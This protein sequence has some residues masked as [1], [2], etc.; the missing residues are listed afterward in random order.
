MTS[1]GLPHQVKPRTDLAASLGTSSL[2]E[3]PMIEQL[4][5]RNIERNKALF[6]EL[7]LEEGL[8]PA[9]SPR[10]RLPRPARPALHARRLPSRGQRAAAAQPP[11]DEYT[12]GFDFGCVDISPTDIKD[13][14]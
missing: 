6:K 12:L 14:I 13:I 8:V 9:A 11:L 2:E 3:L 10:K 4:R 1:D 5:L 7:G